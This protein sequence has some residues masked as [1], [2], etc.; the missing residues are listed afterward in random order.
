MAWRPEAFPSFI[1]R[2]NSIELPMKNTEAKLPSKLVVLAVRGRVLGVN[3]YR[4]FAR[5]CELAEISRADIYDQQKNP[6]GTQRDLSPG[7]ARDAHE[8]VRTHELGFWPEV[9]LYA[10]LKTV[11]TFTPLSD[12]MP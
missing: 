7:H 1:S 3:V 6:T 11:V 8:Y 12:E 4:G 9:F 5:L 2:S 10:R